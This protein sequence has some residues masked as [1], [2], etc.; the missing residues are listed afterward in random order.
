MHETITLDSDPKI[1][2]NIWIFGG[3]DGQLKLA[4]LWNFD[5]TRQ[6]K[7]EEEEVHSEKKKN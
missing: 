6:G 5:E 1:V 4:P 3:C 2:Q 7:H